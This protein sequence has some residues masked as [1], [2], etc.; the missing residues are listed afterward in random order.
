MLAI[1]KLERNVFDIK[2]E[3]DN[4]IRRKPHDQPLS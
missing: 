2:I 1:I 3:Y 4:T